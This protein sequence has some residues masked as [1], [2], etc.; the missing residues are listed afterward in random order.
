[1]CLHDTLAYAYQRSLLL[2][3][4]KHRDQVLGNTLGKVDWE[5]GAEPDTPHGRILFPF[6]PFLIVQ[7][8]FLGHFQHGVE[9]VPE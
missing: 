8:F 6:L 2:E 4:G 7:Q 5:L 1:M 9:Y 3:P